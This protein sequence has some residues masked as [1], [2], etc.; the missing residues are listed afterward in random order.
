VGDYASGTNHTLPTYG[1]ARSF[2][3]VSL[4]SFYK[5]ITFQRITRKGLE[6]LGPIVQKL[7]RAE[8]LDAHAQAVAIR[9]QSVGEESR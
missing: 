3:G 2:S 4:D 7:A 5:K 6:A 8:S 9:L 1:W